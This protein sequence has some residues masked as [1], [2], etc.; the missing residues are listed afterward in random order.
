MKKSFFLTPSVDTEYKFAYIR[1]LEL[2]YT[3]FCRCGSENEST[4]EVQKFNKTFLELLKN[5]SLDEINN[6]K[7]IDWM[8]IWEKIISEQSSD[9]YVKNN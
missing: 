5:K 7:D 4:T 9:I 8:V 1:N 6:R 2:L 3:L